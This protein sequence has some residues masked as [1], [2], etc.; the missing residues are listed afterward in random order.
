MVKLVLVVVSFLRI[1]TTPEELVELL[2]DV[3]EKSAEEAGGSVVSVVSYSEESDVSVSSVY[4][5]I[6]P[7]S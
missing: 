6:V 7:V 3:V 4:G 1:K 5:V 2:W